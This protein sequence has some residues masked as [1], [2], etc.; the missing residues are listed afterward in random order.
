ML[1]DKKVEL[2]LSYIRGLQG[3][4]SERYFNISKRKTYQAFNLDFK[5][6][7]FRLLIDR[8]FSNI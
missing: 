2:H 8:S 7:R 3:V 4:P 5:Q 6:Q 1:F